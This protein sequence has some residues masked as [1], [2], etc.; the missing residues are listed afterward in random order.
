MQVV[1]VYLAVLAVAF[2]FLIVRPQRRQLAARRELIG[3][4][5][6]GDEVITAGGIY[7]RVRTI[8]ETTLEIEVADGV[9]LTLAR[10]AIAR[11]REDDEP[12]VDESAV[13][14]PADTEGAGSDADATGTPE[15]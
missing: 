11:R 14:E 6:I 8:G 10:E 12:A 15:D 5:E 13:D 7:G 3:A 4:I 9:V 1:L 2:F